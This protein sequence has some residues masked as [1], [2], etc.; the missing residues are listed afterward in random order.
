M[1]NSFFFFLKN[2]M[3]AGG[4][5]AHGGGVKHETLGGTWMAVTGGSSDDCTTAAA[6]VCVRHR[7]QL[8]AMEAQHRKQ[9]EEKEQ[10]LAALQAE[11]LQKEAA[12]EQRCRKQLKAVHEH[13]SGLLG[14][15][16]GAVRQQVQEAQQT[17]ERQVGVWGGGRG[18][19]LNG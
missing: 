4:S 5:R 12:Q 11:W 16:K 17:L 18:G 1:G 15:M 14:E 13:T 19:A 3:S 8:R 9:L 6:P 7:R 2:M 10:Q